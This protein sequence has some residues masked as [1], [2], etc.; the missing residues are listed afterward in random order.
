MEFGLHLNLSLIYEG[1]KTFEDALQ[2]YLDI[3]QRENYYSPGIMKDK[4]R[5]NIGNLY[6]RQ[7]DYQKAIIEWKKAVDKISKENK[8]LSWISFKKYRKCS[9][10]ITII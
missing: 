1:L 3:I 10:K 5:I 9:Y 7:V 2:I 4:I 6:C 8:E